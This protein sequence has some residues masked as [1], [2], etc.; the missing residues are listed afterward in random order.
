[1]FAQ[2]VPIDLIRL[3]INKEEDEGDLMDG[4]NPHVNVLQ[5]WF[6]RGVCS[7]NGT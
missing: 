3:I 7:G 1:M 2:C 5:I 4:D 6:S